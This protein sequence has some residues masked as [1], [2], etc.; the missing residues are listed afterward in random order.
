M[1]GFGVLLTFILGYWFNWWQLAAAKMILVIP[2]IIGMYFVPESPH[3]YYSK[4]D[5]LRS[6]RHF[7]S[8]GVIAGQTSKAKESLRWLHGSDTDFIKYEIENIQKSLKEKAENKITLGSLLEKSILK[9]FLISFT[10][11]VFLNLSGL[12]IMIFYC[13]AIF[14]YSGSSIS[15][16]IAAIIVGIVLLVSS[17]IAIGAIT[18]YNYTILYLIYLCNSYDL[19]FRVN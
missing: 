11:F 13:N 19:D 7:H 6:P 1:Q 9:P 18:K 10:M 3:W 12:N 8:E 4:G 17:F 14:K 2:F 16:K 15:E 5:L